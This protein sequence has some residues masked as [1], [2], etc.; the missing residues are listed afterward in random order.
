LTALRGL[1]QDVVTAV[2]DLAQL[3]DRF[4]GVAASAA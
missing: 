3:F 2:G 4:V 1:A